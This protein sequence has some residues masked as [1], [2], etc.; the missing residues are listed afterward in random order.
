MRFSAS[1]SCR[2]FACT[3]PVWMQ[4]A[5]FKLRCDVQVTH[6]FKQPVVEQPISQNVLNEP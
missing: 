1:A 6:S 3:A 5:C 4:Q 2:I